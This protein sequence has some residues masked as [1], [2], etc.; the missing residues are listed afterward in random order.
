MS[1]LHLPES[2]TIKTSSCL[3][4]SIIDLS[5]SYDAVNKVILFKGLDLVQCLLKGV[6]G[7]INRS[8]LDHV[9]N[10]FIALTQYQLEG[11]ATWLKVVQTCSTHLHR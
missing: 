2:L 1:A 11:L 6:A 3:L 7:S 9:S 8:Q 10:V 5:P 4:S